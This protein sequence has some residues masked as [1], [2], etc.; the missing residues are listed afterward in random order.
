MQI[1]K[2]QIELRP[3]S[4]A[5]A[6]DLGFA[7]LRSHA[8]AA[9]MAFV[10][11]WLPVIVLCGALTW[12]WPEW[13]G[14]W[15]AVAWWVKPVI[16]RAPLYVLSRQVFGTSVT[17]QEAVRAWPRQLGGG[18]FRLLTWGRLLAAGR[19]LY[20][21]VWQLEHARGKVANVRLRLLARDGT[22]KSA[23][24]FGIVCAHLEV[25]LELGAFSLIGLFFSDGAVSNPFT[26]LL[27][28]TD[29]MQPVLAMLALALFGVCVAIMSPI[30]TACCFT[31]YLNRRAT[32]EAWDL[33][34]KLRQM[35][36]PVSAPAKVRPTGT[37]LA[38]MCAAVCG[39]A[40]LSALMASA[41]P[42]LAA[43]PAPDGMCEPVK[44]SDTTRGAPHNTAQARVRAQV[45]ALYATDDLRGYSCEQSWFRK[46]K[47][48]ADKK[49]PRPDTAHWNGVAAVIKV[50][51]IAAAIGVA[52]WLLYRYRDKL[53]RFARKT[54]SI[55]A[56]E[57]GG[58]D[59]RAESLPA[60][61]TKAV[62][63][64]WHGGQ[65]RAALALLYRATL[66]RL[67]SL[68]ILALRQGDTEGDCLRLCHMALEQGRLAQGRHAIAIAATTLWLNGAY[69][70]RWPHGDEVAAR[71]AQWDAQF[72]A[73]Q[74]AA[75]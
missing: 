12:L 49:K 39:A 3:R 27:D 15:I 71:C 61:V 48:K 13:S 33:E 23:F 43:A 47:T 31:L 1:D 28:D 74:G 55:A 41:R 37:R 21:P 16:E 24:W 40:L 53:P 8:G 34:I 18:S 2:L 10:A 57:V 56:T 5:Q 75:A 62:L 11:L 54:P 29:A 6:L 68:E 36:P 70:A 46:Q 38:N 51:L 59:I 73:M 60:E 44:A 9:Y 63:A 17:W 69:G 52:G 14:M 22:G 32:L 35:T 50:V 25:V 58:L 67:V 65:Q 66:S 30:Y 72:D 45:D 19:G 4:H 42:A 7:L 26:L 64:L 20:Q